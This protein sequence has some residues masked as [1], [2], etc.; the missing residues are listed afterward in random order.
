MEQGHALITGALG[1][2]RLRKCGQRCR[3]V[4]GPLYDRIA[5]AIPPP[6]TRSCRAKVCRSSATAAIALDY[7]FPPIDCPATTP[8]VAIP[9]TPGRV[10]FLGTDLWS[11]RLC[12]TSD[13]FRVTGAGAERAGAAVLVALRGAN[14]TSR[15]LGEAVPCGPGCAASGGAHPEV[16][17]EDGLEPA[18][19]AEH[20]LTAADMKNPASLRGQ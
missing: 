6:V 3:L 9:A 17:A 10:R 18:R 1:G 15:H 20:T 14:R 8:L 13:R 12:R 5:A 19:A 16:G 2:R 7:S 4:S 11:G